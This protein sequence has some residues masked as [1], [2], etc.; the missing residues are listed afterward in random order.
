MGEHAQPCP[1][2]RRELGEQHRQFASGRWCPRAAI[3][4][5]A[6]A[7]KAKALRRGYWFRPMPIGRRWRHLFSPEDVA[8]SFRFA[9]DFAERG[10]KRARASLAGDR[11]EP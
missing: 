4:H 11:A 10:L 1:F 6:L 3:Y 5:R 7:A 9:L 2:C 8:A